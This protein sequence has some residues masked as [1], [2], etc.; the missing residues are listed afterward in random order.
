MVSCLGCTLINDREAREAPPGPV[1]PHI[2][3]IFCG[4]TWETVAH[5]DVNAPRRTLRNSPSLFLSFSI[6]HHA[7]F[8][9]KEASIC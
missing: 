1:T 4:P 9:I 6:A 5:L 8:A 3:V 2:A 7:G